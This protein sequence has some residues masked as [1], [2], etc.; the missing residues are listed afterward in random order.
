MAS[1]YPAALDNLRS[2][3]AGTD[4]ADVVD[5][6]GMHND[7]RDAIKAVQAE[8]GTDP[9]G[10]APTIAQRLAEIESGTRIPTLAVDKVSGAWQSPAANT[11]LTAAD[12]VVAVDTTAG[13]RT[14]T[15]PLASTMT[16]RSL[17]I[18]KT[19][20][21]N[22]LTVQRQGS[23]LL[24]PGGKTAVAFP[25]DCAMGEIEVVSSG[26]G[27][28]VVSGQAS[29][30]S[31]GSRFYRWSQ[32]LA[33][34][35]TGATVGWVLAGFDSGWRNITATRWWP[36]A[37]A[38]VRIRRTLD[39]VQLRIRGVSA[40]ALAAV[41]VPGALP[42][43]FQPADLGTITMNRAQGDEPI[44]VSF[45]SSGDVWF[46]KSATPGSLSYGT[47]ALPAASALPVSLPG[48]A[49]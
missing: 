35:G 43:G 4:Q 10:T 17:R 39:T 13:A 30:E 40:G 29:D 45:S 33:A 16:G 5:H 7:E 25:S 11:T 21:A 3:Y 32:A 6:A 28:R 20:G 15:L 19:G 26:T 31:V 41:S 8:L 34:S 12:S 14:V 2:D 38:T 27:W 46:T 18:I 1:S 23:D 24:T 48:T 22:T 42:A 9:S 49:G 37:S 47:V 36:L 44:A